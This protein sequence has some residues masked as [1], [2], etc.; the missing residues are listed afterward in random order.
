MLFPASIFS[1]HHFPLQISQFFR[2]E[3]STLSQTTNVFLAFTKRVFYHCYHKCAIQH[4][5]SNFSRWATFIGLFEFDITLFSIIKTLLT[6]FNYDQLYLKW[7]GKSE[8][9]KCL[10]CSKQCNNCEIWYQFMVI[11]SILDIIWF[12]L[13]KLEYFSRRLGTRF[14]WNLFKSKSFV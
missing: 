1:W 6:A 13:K 2:L 8:M 4:W 3:L 10:A 5:L 11:V 14:L 9:W 12:N 7:Y